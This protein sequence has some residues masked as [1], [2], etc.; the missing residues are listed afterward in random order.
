MTQSGRGPADQVLPDARFR[1][2]DAV[3][4]LGQVMRRR[5]FING[6]GSSVAAWPMKA[7]AQ[8]RERLRRIGVLFAAATEDDPEYESRLAAFV[9]A[10]KDLGW[11]EGLNF[12]LDI[13]RPKPTTAAIRGSATEL[14]AT[15]PDVIVS[16]GTTT[17]GP[18]LQVTRTVPIVFTSIVDPVGAG[19]I[20]SLA[21]PGGNATG[22]MQFDYSLSTKWL[23]LLKQVSPATTR[24][25][26]IRDATTTA[27]IGQFAVIQS[28]SL[29]IG[30]DVIPINARDSGETES[31]IGNFARFPNGGLIATSGA[32]LNTHRDLILM[33]AV[34]YRL[35]TVY[36]RRF[37]VDRGGLISY[38]PNLIAT[39]SLA[40]GYVDRILKG[41]KPADLP[42]QAP[43][44]YELAIN[45]KTAKALGLTVAPAL[46][47]RA[48]E[49]IE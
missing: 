18:L 48:D 45:L 36:P 22:F 5:D 30:I 26:V 14:V 20:E 35:P 33:L 15:K 24:A 39:S 29:A 16:A 8:Q 3:C 31:A 1:R 17:T 13:Y 23:E 49:V 32:V 28:V 47:A 12:K 34:R 44:N 42:V 38:G 4:R 7:G 43:T 6:I 2:Y 19:F 25:G 37:F 40:A 11:I 10:L 9:N 27:G 46:I 21:R 41:E